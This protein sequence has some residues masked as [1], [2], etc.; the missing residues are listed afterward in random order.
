MEIIAI[1]LV[2]FIGFKFNIIGTVIDIYKKSIASLPVQTLLE[3]QKKRGLF[4]GDANAISNQLIERAWDN[5]PDIFQ[6]KFGQR[7]HKLSTST[8]ALA[9]GAQRS[10]LEQDNNAPAL[11]MALGNAL[12]ELNTNG[13]LYPFQNIDHELNN[14]SM[15]IYI[16]LT[17]KYNN[18]K[19]AEELSIK[20][21]NSPNSNYKSS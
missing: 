17:E 18:P 2:V 7:P 10:T 21:D 9:L 12:I 6:G 5:K 16:E 4:E 3:H 19:L 13:N 14:Q 11:T 1:A 8:Y 15:A 20:K